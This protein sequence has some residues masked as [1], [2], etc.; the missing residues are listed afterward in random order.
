MLFSSENGVY[1]RAFSGAWVFRMVKY[2]DGWAF[3][4]L[5]AKWYLG[6]LNVI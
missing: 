6:V 4:C 1:I 5:N 2:G 3:R